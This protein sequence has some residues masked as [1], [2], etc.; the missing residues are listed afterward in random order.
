MQSNKWSSAIV[1]GLLLALITIAVMAIRYTLA[2]TGIVSI[3]IW[4]IKIVAS[5]WLL[6]YLI[7]EF[8]KPADIFTYKDGFIYGSIVCLVSTVVCT[9]ATLIFMYIFADSINAQME[10]AMSMV[11]S[12]NPE[13][14]E[15][16]AEWM[17]SGLLTVI[18]CVGSFVWL[19]L[20]GIIAS[21]ILANFT[22]KGS[23]VF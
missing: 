7:K 21:A 23:V 9:L 10:T 1:S 5:I 19:Y 13:A 3:L 2:P 4:L 22:K 16:L 17:K 20:F 11:G 8:A 6:Y 15:K 18:A 14:V 12:S